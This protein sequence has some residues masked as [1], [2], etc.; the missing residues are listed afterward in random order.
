M[1]SFERVLVAGVGLIG[2]SWALGLRRAGF[3]G[4]ILGFDR[5][6][7]LERIRASGA[8]DE[9]R[10][11]LPDDAR[12]GDLVVLAV[13]VGATVELL[14]GWARA[15]PDGVVVT[16]VGSTKRAVCEAARGLAATFVGGHPMAGSV[17]SG[18]EAARAD[19]FAGAPWFLVAGEGEAR[20]RVADMVASFGA[21]PVVVDPEEHDRRVALGSHLPQLVA[22]ALASSAG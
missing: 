15:L 2:G 13:P 19:L 22:S 5:D 14:S 10:A 4:K 18:V 1:S 9:A 12:A 7:V 17:R 20:N 8:V 16:D 3:T 21:H 6:E 11:G